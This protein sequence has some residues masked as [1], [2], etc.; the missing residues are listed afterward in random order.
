MMT[1]MIIMCSNNNNDCFGIDNYGSFNFWH[2]C[3]RESCT[4]RIVVWLRG[5]NESLPRRAPPTAGVWW[6]H[7]EVSGFE[8]SIPKIRCFLW[9]HI[10]WIIIDV[11][12]IF[13]NA[14]ANFFFFLCPPLST[15]KSR[16]VVKK[17]GSDQWSWVT[18]NGVTNKL[19]LMR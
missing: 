4:V 19:L 5:P 16:S 18:R 9:L 6:G 8:T 3:W 12:F 7:R 1:V 11:C 10:R 14:I 2:Y 17:K 15:C 13:S